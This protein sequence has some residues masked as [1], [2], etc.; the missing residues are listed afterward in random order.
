[1]QKRVGILRGGAGEHYHASLRK[2][3]EV[4]SYLSENLGEKYKPLDIFVDKEGVW[5]LAGWPIKLSD[6]MH[7]VDIVWN[8]AHAN[9]SHSLDSLAIPHVSSA[10]FFSALKES[11][12]LLREHMKKVGVALPRSIVLPSYQKDFDL[13]SPRLR[14]GTAAQQK[15]E[16]AIRK[17]KEIHEKFGAP[18][19]VKSITLDKNMGIHLAKTFSEL[20]SAIEDGVAHEQSIIVEEFITGKVDA[21]HTVSGFR[22][23][24]V[25]VFPLGQGNIFSDAEKEKLSVLARDLHQHLSAGHYLKCD[26]LITPRGKVYLL[27]FENTPDLREGSHLSTVCGHAGAKLPEVVEHMLERTLNL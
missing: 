17:A 11:K 20:V 9:F 19:I 7:R 3:G 18:W 22:D 4:I 26:F 25:Y 23:E 5:H 10:P 27:E 16:Y 14:Q 21:L 6:L 12:E 13:P 24:D 15:K 8:V 2:G 1:M